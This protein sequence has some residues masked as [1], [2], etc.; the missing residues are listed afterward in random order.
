MIKRMIVMLLLCALIL[1]SVF[2]YKIY[3]GIMQRKAMS[4]MSEPP[5]SVST[6]KASTSP[7]QNEIKSVGTA[8]ATQ[9][10]N[11]APEVAGIVETL[12]FESGQDVEKGDILLRLRSTEEQ[13]NLAALTAKL[14]LAEITVAR[15]EK[16]IKVKAIAQATYDADKANL[17]NL[18]AQ[19]S[20][21]QALLNK[22]N[23]HAPFAGRLGI[24]Q[25]S[26]G[27]YVNAGT[28]L[29]TLQ[30]LSP[31][32][33]DFTL[34]QQ[35]LT[36]VE[37]GQFI[38][39]RTDAFPQTTFK[40]K[41]SALD[42]QIDE[43]TRNINVRAVF[44]NHEKM[45]RP[46]LFVSLSLTIGEPETHLTLPQTAITFNPYGSTVYIVEESKNKEGQT[47]ARAKMKFV[48]TGA[49][50]GDQIAVLEG[51]KEG[52]EVITSGQIKLRNETP[53]IVNNKIHP[54][55]NPEPEPKDK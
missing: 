20:Q 38:E 52:N 55:N 2:G 43:T 1:G 27:Q 31:L 30:Q 9:G 3:G 37:V 41:I 10:I 36:H 24:R 40:G 6:I 14:K 26:L 54:A 33:V 23:I 22:K 17:D 4:A 53:I 39:A 46:G 42:A 21:Q 5:Q 13:A 8:H 25:I 28:A 7:W 35:N 50:R 48:K 32:Y 12:L 11:I 29:V 19:V 16:Q 34:P 44:Q 49:T 51:I 45:L 15:D 18:L 47:Q